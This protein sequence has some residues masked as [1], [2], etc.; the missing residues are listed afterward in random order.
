MFGRLGAEVVVGP[1]IATVRIPD[2]ALLRQR[3]EEIAGDP[4]DYLIANTGMGMRTWL[5]AADEWGLGDALRRALQGT[6]LAARGPKAAGALSSA[7]LGTW[8]RS[9]HEQLSD[10]VD[11]LRD[12]GLEGRRV[13]FQ[14]HGD[15]GAEFVDRLEAEGAEV[16]RV[17]VYAWRLPPDP[18]PARQLIERTCRGGVDAI[19]FTA[20]PQIRAMLQLADESGQAEELASVLSAGQVVVGCIGPVCAS[21]AEEAGLAGIVV[22][23]HWRLGSL[24]KAVAAALSP[25]RPD[26][27]DRP[28][29]PGHRGRPASPGGD[30]SRR[31]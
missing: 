2:P 21:V 23:D 7:G 5:E 9:P 8:W 29:Q 15:D 19:T 3:T 10:V 25:P 16:I 4:P 28:E 14:L 31:G 27:P 6:R 1:T 20:G 11:H 30:G 24:V 13:A 12:E 26:H 18:G 22:P 17:P